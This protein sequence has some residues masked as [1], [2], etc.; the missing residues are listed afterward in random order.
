[1]QKDSFK[2]SLKLNKKNQTKKV[3]SVGPVPK[4]ISK[5]LEVQTGPP[6]TFLKSLEVQTGPFLTML[7]ACSVGVVVER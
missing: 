6:D 2:K 1:M 7:S 3:V 5:S 4:P